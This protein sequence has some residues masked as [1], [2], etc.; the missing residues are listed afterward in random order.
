MGLSHH[1]VCGSIYL[2]CGAPKGSRSAAPGPDTYRFTFALPRGGA[3]LV[4]S[5]GL[6]REQFQHFADIGKFVETP[7]L[8]KYRVSLPGFQ[9]ISR[10]GSEF[11]FD[12]GI[13]QRRF[14]VALEEID[15]RHLACPGFSGDPDTALPSG[16]ISG[17]ELRI[18]AHGHFFH[19]AEQFRS[20]DAVLGERRG[21][22]I[23]VDE[24]GGNE[25]RDAV[26]RGFAGGRMPQ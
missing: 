15:V 11:C 6:D 18:F 24:R 23:T 13:R 12:L 19:Q 22:N 14:N 5:I 10:Q 16:G 25:L 7:K 20:T 2:T 4:S 17:L 9:R 8:G 3:F 1:P 21:G 26:I